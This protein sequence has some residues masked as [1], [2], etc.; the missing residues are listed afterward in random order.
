MT[1]EPEQPK[2][3]EELISECQGLVRSLAWQIHSRL[4]KSS[5]VDDLIAYGQ[6]GLAEAARD[7]D[8]QRGGKFSTFA[9]Y[10][11]RGAIYDGMSK[12][13]WFSRAQ[14][15]KIRQAQRANEVMNVEAEETVDS[16]GGQLSGDVQW[17]KRLAGNL[18][19]SYLVGEGRE[20]ESE[21]IPLVDPSTP[22]PQSIAMTRELHQVL[23][24]LIDALP[25][26][27]AN[28][29]R[30]AYFEGLTLQ[31]AGERLGVSKAWASRLHA[32]ALERLARALRQRNLAE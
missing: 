23:R 22:T 28:L 29:I 19:V 30:A 5:D 14:Y 32:R 8:P 11:I 3:R 25:V 16:P 18:A 10:R 27:S 24:Q 7:F 6:V 12:M 20:G 26:D 9:Y 1:D 31:E 21:D 2:S 17:L 4:G 15:R 13:S